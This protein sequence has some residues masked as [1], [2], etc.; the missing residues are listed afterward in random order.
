VW[1]SLRHLVPGWSASW[2]TCPSPALGDGLT[3]RRA[4]TALSPTAGQRCTQG[5]L[6]SSEEFGREVP[7]R[8]QGNETK[9]G[10]ES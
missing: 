1:Q 9:A 3:P 8:S 4:P 7:A 10:E 6:L 2:R 5:A